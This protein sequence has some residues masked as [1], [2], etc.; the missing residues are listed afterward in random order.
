[1]ASA[2]NQHVDQLIELSQ[3]IYHIHLFLS[4]FPTKKVD[5]STPYLVELTVSKTN[6]SPKKHYFSFS[7]FVEYSYSG[8]AIACS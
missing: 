3:Q 2:K 1:M 8:I 7:A 6:Q 5:V 4:Y